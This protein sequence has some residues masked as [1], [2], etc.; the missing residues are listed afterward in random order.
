MKKWSIKKKPINDE[1]ATNEPRPVK[2]ISIKHIL[3]MNFLPVTFLIY[4][5][6]VIIVVILLM[7]WPLEDST[8]GSGDTDDSAK[9]LGTWLVGDEGTTVFYSN[10]SIYSFS[11]ITNFNITND[12]IMWGTWEVL[13]DEKVL[14]EMMGFPITYDYVF[15]N[16]NHTLTTTFLD[17][18]IVFTKE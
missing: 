4:A 11:T 8:K 6:V 1:I 18:T 3:K 17:T 12:V 14:I 2:D 5:V 16:D 10:G 9:F 13:A 7:G 15:S